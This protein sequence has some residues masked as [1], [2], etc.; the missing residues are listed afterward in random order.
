LFSMII[1]L[2]PG[3][4]LFMVTSSNMVF[5]I[6]TMIGDVIPG[7]PPIVVPLLKF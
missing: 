2:S 7:S 4:V 6:A 5:F 3:S 1:G